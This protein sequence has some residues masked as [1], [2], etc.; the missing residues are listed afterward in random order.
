M[1]LV[2][3]RRLPRS[4]PS[5][6]ATAQPP[7]AACSAGL[8]LA[9]GPEAR[10]Q[11]QSVREGTPGPGT[12]GPRDPA[13]PLTQAPHTGP[14]VWLLIAGSSR[15][16][17]SR[18]VGLRPHFGSDAV[19]IIVPHPPDRSEHR[20]GQQGALPRPRDSPVPQPPALL[21]PPCSRNAGFP[22][23]VADVEGRPGAEAPASRRPAGQGTAS[24]PTPRRAGEPGIP[25]PPARPPPPARHRL[26]PESPSLYLRNAGPRVSAPPWGAGTAARRGARRSVL[27]REAGAIVAVLRPP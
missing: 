6:W 18:G 19:L 21:C 16:S 23:A 2:R 25:G 24:G 1:A 3:G 13:C 10:G 8:H 9:G 27:T 20:A 11:C 12:A 17:S 22:R 4:H 14:R 15:P 7:P 26:K 5:P